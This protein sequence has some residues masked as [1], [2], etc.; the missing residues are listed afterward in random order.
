MSTIKELWLPIKGYEGLYE[1]SNTGYVKSLKSNKI[2]KP[3]SNNS[4]LLVNLYKNK[5]QKHRYIHRLVAQTFIPNPDNSPEVNHID[6]DKS[7]NLVKNLEWCD[8]MYNLKH[9]YDNGLKRIGELHGCHKLTAKEVI[10]IRKEYVK[11]DREHS[12]HALG[13]KYG[14]SWCTI[15]AI[16]KGRLWSHLK[17]GDNL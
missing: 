6:C 12:L 17:E 15:Q 14:V 4:Y 13:E 1:V 11:N 7:N 8:R 3:Y 16:I 5:S 9:S 2:L 10:N